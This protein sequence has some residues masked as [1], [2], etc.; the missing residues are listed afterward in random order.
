MLSYENNEWIVI[1]T[2]PRCVKES[3]G[4]GDL[5]TGRRMHNVLGSWIECR[6]CGWWG[7]EHECQE[8]R[9]PCEVQQVMVM[10]IEV[11][12]NLWAFALRKGEATEIMIPEGD[13]WTLPPFMIKAEDCKDRIMKTGPCYMQTALKILVARG[14][15]LPGAYKI[16]LEA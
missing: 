6:L 4:R 10:D 3:R 1:K 11:L 2:C 13:H 7:D 12:Q 9:F 5:S 15:L 16:V 8:Y 14:C